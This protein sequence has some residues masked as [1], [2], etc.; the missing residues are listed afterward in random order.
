MVVEEQGNE[1]VLQ[2]NNENIQ[3]IKVYITLLDIQLLFFVIY[4]VLDNKR[5]GR[6]VGKDRVIEHSDLSFAFSEDQQKDSEI[7]VGNRY[8]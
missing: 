4:L 2:E 3:T 5:V 8:R 7:K 1:V 6:I